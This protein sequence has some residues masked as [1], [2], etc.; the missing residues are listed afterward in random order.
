M[1]K[2]ERLVLKITFHY[3]TVGLR[4]NQAKRKKEKLKVS[5]HVMGNNATL[6]GLRAAS[7]Q[8]CRA[9]QVKG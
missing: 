3:F 7:N 9:T 1:K 2:G 6:Q 5:K 4:S 8:I